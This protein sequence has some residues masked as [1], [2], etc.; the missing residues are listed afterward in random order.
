MLQSRRGQPVPRPCLHPRR[1]QPAALAAAPQR[2]E[3]VPEDLRAERVQ[4]RQVRGHGVVRVIPAHHGL[5]PRTL[6]VDGTV[7]AVPLHRLGRET[8]QGE[9]AVEFDGRFYRI[10]SFDDAGR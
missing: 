4:A 7:A 1:V 8:Q 3:P 2:L 10:T 9:V 5:Q 6:L